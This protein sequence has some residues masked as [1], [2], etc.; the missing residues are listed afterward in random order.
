MQE[1][2]RENNKTKAMKILVSEKNIGSSVILITVS[3]LPYIKT[4]VSDCSPA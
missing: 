2:I 4:T 1:K 3:K